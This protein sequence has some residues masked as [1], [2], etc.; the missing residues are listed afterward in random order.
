MRVLGEAVTQVI[1]TDKNA[2]IRGRQ[3]PR[4]SRST[5][6][7]PTSSPSCSYVRVVVERGPTGHWVASPLPVA[8]LPSRLSHTYFLDI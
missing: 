8:T 2:V 5:S 3:P 7:P 6:L 4:S 1:D